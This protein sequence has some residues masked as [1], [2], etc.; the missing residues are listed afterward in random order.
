MPGSLH[1]LRN[2]IQS[3]DSRLVQLIC[4]RMHVVRQIA[5]LKKTTGLPI[6][7]SSREDKVLSHILEHPHAEIGTENLKRLFQ[8]I[9]E[10]SRQIQETVVAE[11]DHNIPERS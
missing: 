7:D 1:D 9:L 10:I 8:T 5:E 11:P 4:K 6:L 3:L 2:E